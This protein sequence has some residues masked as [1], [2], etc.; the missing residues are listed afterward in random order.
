MTYM[1][2]QLNGNIMNQKIINKLKEEFPTEISYILTDLNPFDWE[3][4][5]YEKDKLIKITDE[6]FYFN[7]ENEPLICF[8]KQLTNDGH[9]YDIY[10]GDRNSNL[11]LFELK[12][13]YFWKVRLINK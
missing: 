12:E 11:V 13:G 5:S 4:I 1:E 8:Q 2:K 9:T 10:L 3:H 6:L 7:D